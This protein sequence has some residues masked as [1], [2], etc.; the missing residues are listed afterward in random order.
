MGRLHFQTSTHL[1]DVKEDLD[2]APMVVVVSEER[3]EEK[4]TKV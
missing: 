2:W 3:A 1:S 4:F